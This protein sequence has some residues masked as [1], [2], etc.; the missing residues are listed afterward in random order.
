[1]KISDS[2]VRDGSFLFRWRSYLP[3]VLLLPL[4]LALRE[5]HHVEVA[6]GDRAHDIWVAFCYLISLSGLAV[7][8]LVVGLAAPGTSGRNVAEQRAESLNRTGL[9]SVVRHPLYLGNF[10]GIIG[11]VMSTM[12]WWFVALTALAY[13]LYIERIMATE[14]GFL[15]GRFGEDFRAWAARTPAF[16]PRFSGWV[17]SGRPFSFRTVLRREYNGV[18]AVA[19]CF[20]V[21]EILLDVAVAGESLRDWI[22]EDMAWLIAF[23]LS[24]LVFLSLRF[25]KKRTKMLNAAR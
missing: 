21:F 6:I 10:L 14:E 12:V 22:E 17:P 8:A 3:L 9:Y 23:G 7:R 13:W 11:I 24:A 1:M 20:L 16:L 25:L 18:L 5:A 4:V 15:E 2:L 19:A